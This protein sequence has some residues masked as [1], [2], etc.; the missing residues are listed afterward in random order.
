MILI[1]S[2]SEPDKY[3][4]SGGEWKLKRR[5]ER[6]TGHPCVVMNYPEVS[7]DFVEKYGVRAIFICGF[8][9]G[10]PK[11]SPR[12][13]RNI[14]DLLHATDIPTLGACGGHQLIGFVFNKD[15][16]K[17]KRLRDE[18][19]RKLKPGEPDIEPG[20]HPGYF[21]ERGVHYVEVVRRDPLFRGLPRKFRVVEAHYCEVKQLPPGFTL[22]ATNA[23]CC[24]QAMRCDERP[25]YGVQFHPEAWTDHY[26]DGKRIMTNFFR[27]AG[28]A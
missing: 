16:R 22:L 26:P 14:S 3:D 4:S 10:W 2:M 25:I 24:I 12:N 23:N 8:G 17:L 9:Y 27:I 28:L 7:L 21:T 19:M 1:V 5:F 6:I 13:L 20:Y 11:V 15:V 18:P